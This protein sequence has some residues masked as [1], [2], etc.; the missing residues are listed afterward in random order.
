MEKQWT[1]EIQNTRVCVVSCTLEVSFYFCEFDH[2]I[3]SSQKK[4]K[5]K[6]IINSSFLFFFKKIMYIRKRSI[7][8]TRY[9]IDQII[10]CLNWFLCNKNMISIGCSYITILCTNWFGYA[11]TSWNACFRW[12]NIEKGPQRHEG[13]WLVSLSFARLRDW[14]GY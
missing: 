1:H 7:H 2:Q 3:L 14:C 5:G 10:R 13:T 6:W 12:M 8:R 9:F 4:K 11:S